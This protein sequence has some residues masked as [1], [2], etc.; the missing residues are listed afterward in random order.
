MFPE[1][2]FHLPGAYRR[3][4][5][6]QTVRDPV[7]LG[8][9]LRIVEVLLSTGAVEENDGD[10]A[11]TG[12][13]PDEEEPPLELGHQVWPLG[14]GMERRI[15]PSLRASSATRRGATRAA[16]HPAAAGCLAAAAP[17]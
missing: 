12:H 1:D 6:G 16:G 13:E 15:G 9:Q 3:A 10:E 11:A 8:R 5:G 17:P 7:G 14:R 4:P 2:V